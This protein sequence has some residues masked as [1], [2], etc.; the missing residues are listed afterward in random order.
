MDS[1]DCVELLLLLYDELVHD[2]LKLLHIIKTGCNQHYILL[3]QLQYD[4]N[5][6]KRRT[7]LQKCA[8]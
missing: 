1:L 7:E 6:L 2:L 4:I 8:I 3:L 5:D